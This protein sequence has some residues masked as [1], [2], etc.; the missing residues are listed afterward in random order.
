VKQLPCLQ[1]PIPAARAVAATLWV[2]ENCA[3]SP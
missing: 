2:P 3:H 1:N